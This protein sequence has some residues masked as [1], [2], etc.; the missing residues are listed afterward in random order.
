[1]CKLLRRVCINF[2][3]KTYVTMEEKLEKRRES[4]D[5]DD[6]NADIYINSTDGLPCDHPIIPEGDVD[7]P[8]VNEDS[9]DDL[10]TSLIVTNI[11]SE[12][13]TNDQ[14]KRNLEELFKAFG[15]N[16]T[17]QWLKSFRR[18]R[19]VLRYKFKSSCLN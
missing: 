11:L 19:Y 7:E 18:L 13:F 3:V 2:G 17:F 12:V 6:E 10:P 8:D 14:M 4:I 15:D 5:A 1:M 9:F 16:V